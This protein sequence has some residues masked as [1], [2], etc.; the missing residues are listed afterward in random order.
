MVFQAPVAARPSQA[1]LSVAVAVTVVVGLTLCLAGYQIGGSPVALSEKRAVIGGGSA[2]SKESR[3]QITH[4][5]KT[6]QWGKLHDLRTKL[7][8]GSATLSLEPSKKFS[9]H[10]DKY[11]KDHH[12]YGAL[13]ERR[14]VKKA[15][16]AKKNGHHLSNHVMARQE[17]ISK[18]VQADAGKLPKAGVANKQAGS[19]N[20][21]RNT[22]DQENQANP[23]Q[24][25]ASANG[26]AHVVENTAGCAPGD[27]NCCPSG[28]VPACETCMKSCQDSFQASGKVTS[29]TVCFEGC[30]FQGVSLQA[31]LK[32]FHDIYVDEK[33][34]GPTATP[35]NGR[36]LQGAP[37]DNGALTRAASLQ[38]DQ[39]VGC[40][41]LFPDD[42]GCWVTGR[43]SPNC[44]KTAANGTVT[45]RVKAAALVS[46]PAP[47]AAG[48]PA[49]SAASVPASNAAA[50]PGAKA[51]VA[52]AKAV[53]PAKA[54]A[55]EA[56]MDDV[57]RLIAETMASSAPDEWK[58]TEADSEADSGADSE[59][60]SNST[61][62]VNVT[63]AAT[64]KVTA[65]SNATA[66]AAPNVTAAAKPAAATA[67][68][69]V[70]PAAAVAA[71]K[72][73]AVAAVVAKPATAAA[74]AKSVPTAAVA[75]KP[76]AAVTTAK[77]A[78]VAKPAAAA[79][80]QKPPA[81]QTIAVKAM[82]AKQVS[83]ATAAA[84]PAAA[85]AAAKTAAAAAAAKPAAKKE[86]SVD[87]MIAEIMA[88]KR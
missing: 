2:I 55:A 48:V 63:A 59:A 29:A 42:V 31:C 8:G 40:H 67:A 46:V 24:A 54:A 13:H 4:L 78:V 75:A 28:T 60:D 70:K 49:A 62:P 43:W 80:A 88:A 37:F 7:E 66:A 82:V 65:K 23:P 50:V 64:P 73:A 76:A 57:D 83:P 74:A 25:F 17:K 36:R 32:N 19:A 51:A 68:T 20:E 16:D 84:K 69:V 85:V 15:V 47:K 45:T 39:A 26:N 3:K 10:D 81:G 86:Q 6:H 87:E 11:L 53:V 34:N 12:L 71:A 1:R 5:K 30:H 77:P 41:E 14:L 79:A 61:V 52:P 56:P 21:A 33:K 72:Q 35:E 38:H 22:R 9:G 27:M 44:A 58:E 18:R